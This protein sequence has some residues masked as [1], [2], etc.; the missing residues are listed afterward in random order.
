MGKIITSCNPAALYGNCLA[1]D[2]SSNIYVAGNFVSK[3]DSL[4]NI[5]WSRD[6]NTQGTA[7]KADSFGNL[8][9]TGSF[10]GTVDFNPGSG[11]YYKS[12]VGDWNAYVLKLTSTNTGIESVKSFDVT[13]SPNPNAG[14]VVLT[15]PLAAKFK[16][17]NSHGQLVYA[18][19]LI[20]GKNTIEFPLSITSGLYLY[21]V[22]TKQ[23]EASGNMILSR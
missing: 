17:F 9:L 6:M 23:G 14:Q 4:G 20:S 1:V 10:E 16:L 15:V 21:S 2:Q 11:G 3:Y 22:I 5:Q 7:M 12:S 18:T 8:Y 13:V 19:D